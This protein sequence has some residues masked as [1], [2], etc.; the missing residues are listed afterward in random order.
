MLASRNVVI[1]WNNRNKRVLID[2]GYEFTKMGEE[3]V[4][5][6]SVLTK[7]STHRVDIVCDY[8][9]TEFQKEYRHFLKG[10]EKDVPTDACFDCGRKKQ[11]DVLE[12]RYGE[13][14]FNKI[15]EFIEKR[16]VSRRHNIEYIRSV[17]QDAG[18]TL[19]ST[20]Y[21]NAK[22][23]LQYVCG[24]HDSEVQESSYENMRM[25][26]RSCRFCRLESGW[27]NLRL[28]DEDVIREVYS[29]GY[30]IYDESN[31]NYRNTSSRIRIVCPKHPDKETYTSLD[32]I[33]EGGGCTY[34]GVEDRSGENHYAWVGGP[35]VTGNRMSSDYVKWM[36][37][38][39]ERYDYQCQKCESVGSNL[40]AHHILNYSSHKEHR[41]DIDNG[42][43]FCNKCHTS[44]HKRYGYRNNT[45]EQLAEFLNKEIIVREH[46]GG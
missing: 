22:E 23:K 35:D 42:I 6:I 11:Q 31:I 17:F 29:G 1:K 20:E 13:R 5:D 38:V 37:S 15:P 24:K 10:R 3:V 46:K 34:C 27:E 7:S 2:N 21:I 32:I 26:G 44:F 45:P 19:L 18:Y 43:V 16:T 9:G 12:E 39:Y 33:R 28:S 36:K 41:Y 30:A 40:N 14:D 8:C 25:H 4:V